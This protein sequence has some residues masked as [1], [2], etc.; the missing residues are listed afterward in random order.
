METDTLLEWERKKRYLKRYRK[1]NALVNRLMRKLE[2]LDIKMQ[3][4]KSPS[5][6]GM[7]RGGDPVTLA[8]LVAD[9]VDLE[10]RI[11]KLK[12]KGEPMRA[13]LLDMIDELEEVRY[14]EVL[15]SFFVDC[16]D[17]PE[18]ADEMGY[19]IRHVKRL[20]SEGLYLLLSCK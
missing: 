9:K 14:A 17:F 16:K 2:I 18:I 13:E 7:P 4:L 15:E 11:E 19:T 3:S 6:S 5:L 20:Y 8:A 12:R 10:K 1:N